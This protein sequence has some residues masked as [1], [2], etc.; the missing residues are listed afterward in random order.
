MDQSSVG[1]RCSPEVQVARIDE[2]TTVDAFDRS[3][4]NT[5]VNYGLITKM[6]TREFHEL[7]QLVARIVIERL[8][9]GRSL[10]WIADLGRFLEQ[11]L[12]PKVQGSFI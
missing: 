10:E 6:R 12:D 9:L 7:G 1:A 11:H 3:A 8:T 4:A 5:C 2:I